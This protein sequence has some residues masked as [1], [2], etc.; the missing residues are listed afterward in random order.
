MLAAVIL[1][2]FHVNLNVGGPTSEAYHLELV[3]ISVGMSLL[4]IV[5]AIL[6]DKE[7]FKKYPK[8]LKSSG[9]LVSDFVRDYGHSTAILNVGIMGIISVSVL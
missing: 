2:A 3:W 7:V 8:L 4:F 6:V 9:R 5:S 1:H